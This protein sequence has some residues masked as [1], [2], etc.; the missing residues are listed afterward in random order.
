MSKM[1]E[2]CFDA[3]HRIIINRPNF[4]SKN[5]IITLDAV[6]VEAGLKKG[7]IR[8]ARASNAKLVEA[9][10]AAADEQ[11]IKRIHL[12]PD[13]KLK[14]MY[15]AKKQE[16]LMFRALYEESLVREVSLLKQLWD[17]RAE[18]AKL[19]QVLTGEKIVSFYERVLEK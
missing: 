3:L 8:R 19:N 6:A 2:S 10:Q 15:E 11:S 18:W 1:T 9:I 4:V 17:E 16:A 7:S 5:S 12:S 14:E 13:K